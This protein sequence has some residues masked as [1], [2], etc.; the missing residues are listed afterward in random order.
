M[1]SYRY[2]IATTG[3]KWYF[4]CY[5]NVIK[6]FRNLVRLLYR[7]S[8]TVLDSGFQVLNFAFFQWNLETGFQQFVRFRIP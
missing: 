7:E 1:S 5:A 3:S 2:A 8:K 6:I 4:Q